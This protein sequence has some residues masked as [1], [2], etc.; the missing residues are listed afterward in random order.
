MYRKSWNNTVK[1][2]LETRLESRNLLELDRNLSS[3][4]RTRSYSTLWNS[5]LTRTRKS[6]TRDNTS[7]YHQPSG[8]LRVLHCTCTGTTPRPSL[9]SAR[10]RCGKGH[11][12]SE[13]VQLQDNN[14]GF[15][16]RLF[17]DYS[18]YQMQA[19]ASVLFRVMHLAHQLAFHVTFKTITSRILP[20]LDASL[21]SCKVDKMTKTIG[22]VRSMPGSQPHSYR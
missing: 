9:P 18:A 14:I 6:S 21:A 5:K 16:L 20:K 12:W 7:H 8:I 22:N 2:L 17:K 19:I 13:S 11:P 1:I 10:T 3:I 4:T 15:S